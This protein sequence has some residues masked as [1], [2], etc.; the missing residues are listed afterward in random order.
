[1]AEAEEDPGRLA[2]ELVAVAVAETVEDAGVATRGGE[3]AV[4]PGGSVWAWAAA[5]GSATSRWH[6]APNKQPARTKI[7]LD[8]ASKNI[9]GAV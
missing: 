6:P 1:M 4:V 8:L 5:S 3:E 7:I 9:R 2:T